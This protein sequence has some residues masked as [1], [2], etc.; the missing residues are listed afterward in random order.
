MPETFEHNNSE[1]TY[2]SLS[3]IAKSIRSVIAKTYNR[4]YWVKAEIVKLN[5]Y[6]YSGH[7]Y[8]DLVEKKNNKIV[9]QLRATIWAGD[10]Q[11]ID[12]KFKKITGEELKEG[13]TVLFLARVTFHE[14]H[15]LSLNIVDIEPA[16]TLGEMAK[17]KKEAI[18]RL[19]KEGLF[20][21]NRSLPFPMLPKSIAVISV[22][23]SKGYHDFLNIIEN[24]K[25]G[26]KLEHFLF[27]ALL[28]G[29]KA[30]DSIVTQLKNIAGK[31]ELFDVVVIIRGG[32]GDVGLNAYDQY[33]L[34]KAVAECPLPVITGIG[35][36][37]NETV[38]EMVAYANKITPTEVAVFLLEKF[39]QFHTRLEDLTQRLIESTEDTLQTHAFDLENV[40]EVIKNQ[41][42]A[43]VER[44][45][46]KI[47]LLSEKLKSGSLATLRSGNNRLNELSTH[48]SYKPKEVVS[49]EKNRISRLTERMDLLLKQSLKN[50]QAHLENLNAK[51]DLL[52]PENVLKRGYSITYVNGKVIRSADQ[53][54]KDAT[55]ITRL[56]DGEI[57]SKVEKIKKSK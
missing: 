38:T 9:A 35:H 47:G 43:T 4:A 26:Y 11:N 14:I 32:G 56:Y 18:E 49:F 30:V 29:D 19:K 15:G 25:Y 17:G 55:L 12:Y 13:M 42:T 2:Y 1:Q 37:T 31:A 16:F 33:K 10:F 5:Y 27:Q 3:E 20:D 24:N 45:K 54:N 36:S 51:I 23:T 48:L 6:P 52:K 40:T 8:P 46:S 53:L 21:H 39:E 34:A 50:H 57:I 28:Q 7:C 44:N 22:E 41:V